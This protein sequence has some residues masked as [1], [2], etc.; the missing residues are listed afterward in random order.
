V[1]VTTVMMTVTA[2]M[3]TMIAVILWMTSARHVEDRDRVAGDSVIS[4]LTGLMLSLTAVIPAMA[5][6]P[7]KMTAASVTGWSVS[8]RRPTVAVVGSAPAAY[9]AAF[10]SHKRP[11]ADSEIA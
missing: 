4:P 3:L 5:R 11:A 1:T 2:A 6:Y 9:P 7:L 8:M 10:R